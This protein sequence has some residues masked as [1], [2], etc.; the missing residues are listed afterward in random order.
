MS[1]YWQFGWQQFNFQA[2]K[3]ALD[4]LR[5]AFQHLEG[6]LLSRT[7][8]VG[9]RL[10]LADV[11][12]ASQLFYPLKLSLDGKFRSAFPATLRWFSHVMAQPAASH[13]V[14]AVVY[15]KQTPSPPKNQNKKKEGKKQKKK[16]QQQQ[17][18]KPAAAKKKKPK[19]P[20]DALPKSSF[21]LDEWKRQYS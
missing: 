8:L 13:V 15:C 12:I 6:H 21:V 5:A 10:S 14:G 19:N 18:P 1:T 2:N 11:V 4:D 7:F 9:Q 3:K 20:L 17:K 16:Q